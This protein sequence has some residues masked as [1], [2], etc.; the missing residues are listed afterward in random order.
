MSTPVYPSSYAVIDPCSSSG[1]PTA[2]KGKTKAESAGEIALKFAWFSNTTSRLL[3]MNEGARNARLND[4]RT[5]WFGDGLYMKVVRGEKTALS[6]DENMSRRP[7]TTH[8][9]RSLRKI[10]S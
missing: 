8:R 2:R 4:T 3:L 7:P 5:V 1:L 10:S 9:N 6:I